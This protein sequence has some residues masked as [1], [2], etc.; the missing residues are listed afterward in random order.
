[1]FST[2]F[3]S[4]PSLA[5]DAFKQANK[6]CNPLAVRAI[7]DTFNTNANIVEPEKAQNL[8]D[9][10]KQDL[11]S[12]NGGLLKAALLGYLVIGTLLLL[13][14]L[15]DYEAFVVHALSGWFPM[16]PGLDDLPGSLFD[17]ETGLL[18]LPKYFVNDVP[19]SYTIIGN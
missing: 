4:V 14:F 11:S 7:F 15:A 8:L 1:M 12:V 2:L 10:Y 19:E 17:S 18:A 3:C 6:D 13:L 9:S 5:Y 16:W